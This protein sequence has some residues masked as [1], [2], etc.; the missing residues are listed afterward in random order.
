M[1]LGMPAVSME[2]CL[3]SKGDVDWTLLVSWILWLY[4]GF[5]SLGTLAGEL[6]R[7]RRTFMPCACMAATCASIASRASAL[8]TGPISVSR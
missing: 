2:R 4:C 3:V 7:P 5:F 6:E 8:I 1:L